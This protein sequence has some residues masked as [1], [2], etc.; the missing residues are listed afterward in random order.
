[1]RIT[2]FNKTKIPKKLAEEKVNAQGE[3]KDQEE[4]HCEY[5]DYTEPGHRD[6][7]CATKDLHQQGEAGCTENYK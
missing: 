7:L 4:Q 2:T 3:T 5:N 6:P 1:M